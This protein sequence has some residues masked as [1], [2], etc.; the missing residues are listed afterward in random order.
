[1]MTF[2][3]MTIITTFSPSVPEKTLAPSE[4]DGKNTDA[5]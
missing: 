5:R 1:M 2:V 4:F 3:R